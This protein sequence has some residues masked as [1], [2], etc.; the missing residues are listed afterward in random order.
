MPTFEDYLNLSL[1]VY[2]DPPSQ[3]I[4][5]NGPGGTQE[6]V[7]LL[8]P[9]PSSQPG[10]YGAAYLNIATNEIIL[11]NRG[12]NDLA[13]V[14]ADLQM[15]L[16]IPPDQL[17]DAEDFYSQV[18]TEAVARGATLSITGHSLGGS[19]TQLLVA[20]HA[21]DVISGSSVF[22]QTFNA[23]GVKG[24]LNDLNLPDAD[25]A[26]TNWVS[27]TDIVSNLADHIGSKQALA[28]LP[29]PFN[30]PLGPVG[31]LTF[32]YDTHKISQVL[33][34]FN[35]E[36]A[37]PLLQETEEYLVQTYVT[38]PG[39]DATID[40]AAYI[41]GN[42]RENIGNELTGSAA[43][44][45]IFGGLPD[46]RIHGGEGRDVIYA[47]AGNDTIWGDAGA[48]I[49]VG[50]DGDDTYI[51]DDP[52]D[53]V[54]EAALG[55][56]DTVVSTASHTLSRNVEQLI[57]EGT[58]P[59]NGTGND[60]DNVLIGNNADN[61]LDGAFGA[62]SMAGG[63]GD[64][65]YVV[66]NSGDLVSE[67]VA[68]GTDIVNSSVSYALTANVENLIL[69]GAE[70]IDGT[71]NELNNILTGNEAA[72]TLTGSGGNDTLRGEAGFDR[73][74]YRTGD[75]T[76]IIEDVDGQGAILY[77]GHLLLGGLRP[78]GSTGAYTSPDGQFTYVQ[79]GDDIVVNGQLTIR[80]G[81]AGQMGMQ[82][83]ELPAAPTPL[84][85]TRSSFVR[86]TAPGSG[87]YEPIFTEEGNTYGPG[88]VV[89]PEYS[90]TDNHLIHALGGDD[91]VITGNGSDQLYG[92]AGH[93]TLS[94]GGGTDSIDGGEGDDL[95]QGG[96]GEDYVLGGLGNDNLNGDEP[97]AE[98][99]GTNNDWLDGGEGHDE[100][101]G[102]AGSDVLFGG[103]GDDLLIGDTTQFQGG[104][105]EAGD[106]D[107]LFGGD[108]QDTLY[109]LY[110]NDL[111]DGGS[112]DDLMAGQD[113]TDVLSGGD[114]NDVL[115]GDLRVQSNGVI[116][117]AEY[118]GAG[119]SDLLDGGL[120]HD[121]LQGGEGNDVLVG[122]AG[123]DTLFGEYNPNALPGLDPLTPT[124]AALSGADYLTGGAGN[125]QLHGNGGDDL[126]YGDEGNDLL[127]GG[128]G[129]D[130]LDGGTG[131]NTLRGGAGDDVLHGH[132][133]NDYLEAGEGSDILR[134]GDGDDILVG[135]NEY[136][137]TGDSF[138]DGG[139]GNDYY[140]IDRPG[141]IVFEMAGH[142]TDTVESFISYALP[143]EVEN[144]TLFRSGDLHGIGN[145]HDNIMQGGTWLEGGEGNDTLIGGTLGQSVRLDGGAGDDTLQGGIPSLT[146]GINNNVYV[147]GH[148]YGQDAVIEYNSGADFD[149]NQIDVVEMM[150]DVSP[151]DVAW[152]RDNNDLVFTLQ[153]TT[154]HLRLTSYFDLTFNTGNY[155][156]GNAYIPPQGTV[157]LDNRNPYY[158]AASR[159]EEIRFADGTTWEADMFGAPTL[160]AYPSDTYHFDRGDGQQTIIDFDVTGNRNGDAADAVQ[161]GSGIA[162]DEVSVSRRGND[163]VLSLDGAEDVLTV[164]S[165][166]SI[167]FAREQHSFSGNYVTAYQMEQV[168]FDDGTIWNAAQ[169]A[170]RVTA[171]AG[172]NEADFLVANSNNNAIDGL[173]GDD[174]IYGQEGD[175]RIDGGA[176]DDRLF[177]NEGNDTYRFGRGGGQDTVIDWNVTGTDLDT[178]EMAPDVTTGDLRVIADQNGG[179]ALSIRG[180]TDQLTLSDFLYDSYSQNK[181]VL[182]ADGTVWDAQE[183]LA[184][185][186]GPTITGTEYPDYLVGTEFN[187]TI[188]GLE[189]EDFLDGREGADLLYGGLDSDEILGGDGNDMLYGEAGDDTLHGGSGG[190]GGGAGFAAMSVEGF[191]EADCGGGGSSGA[192][193]DDLLIGGEG[194][195]TYLFNFGD[196]VDTIVDTAV[197]GE[198]NRLLFG[199]GIYQSD[200]SFEH[201][202]LS[203]VLTI[204]VGF[205]GD[206][207]RLTNFDPSQANGSLAVET[208]AFADGTEVALS[209]FFAPQP[210]LIGTAGGDYLIGTS[211][212]DII[213]AL[214]GNDYLHGQ[215][216]D[217]ILLGGDGDD[218]LVGGAGADTFDG[219][220]GNDRLYVDEFDTQVSGGAGWDE[221]RIDGTVGVTLTTSDIEYFVGGAGGDHLTYSGTDAISMIGREGNDVLNGGS[222]NDS[223]QGGTGADILDGGAGN[224]SLEGEAGDDTLLGGAGDD[225]LQGGAGAD[226]FDG[227]EGNDRLYVDEFDTQVSGGAG[228]DEVRVLSATGATL[229]LSDVEYVVGGEG[230]DTVTSTH[231]E[232]MMM[233]GLAGN[234][235]LTGGS[236][237][238]SLQGGTGADT[239]DGSAG[240]DSLEGEAGDDTLFGGAGSDSLQGGAGADTLEG[241]AGNDQLYGGT[242]NDRY[243]FTSGNGQDTLVDSDSTEVSMDEVAL[244]DG[245]VPLNVV[246][247]RQANDL[248][249]ALAG[250]ND[251]LTVRDW[252][253]G[254]ASQVEQF[255]AST[256]SRLINSNV[257]QLIQAMNTYSQTAGLSWEDAIQ[258]RPDEVQAVIGAYW[259]QPT[260]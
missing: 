2:G 137:E 144:L 45:L 226:T 42:N 113:G 65:V 34:G 43:N 206:A 191:C 48:D 13:D 94:A 207:L 222:G 257:D 104:P 50:E 129:N 242:G 258:Q 182:F 151:T 214:A 4:A 56:T 244:G 32:P 60:L 40:G 92:D 239:L 180:T 169:L 181:R 211:G 156:L 190:G 220:T 128:A 28:G 21:G 121:Y 84:G 136:F 170:S 199:D 143:G 145:V 6:W 146:S 248:R 90:D 134:G 95:L 122:G 18:Q 178:I 112:G 159:V 217:D 232:A 147:F 17:A 107:L 163:L 44:D 46:D 71:G 161:L 162:Q 221:V 238:D 229:T 209:S 67:A 11:V 231:S 118:R 20:G 106:R 8:E 164:H 252:Y 149:R 1:A 196:G 87:L 223:L 10:Y 130:F 243:L 237:N 216:S 132:D 224:D 116:D 39:F 85:P 102:A 227:G 126:L 114:G 33:G 173:A 212:V 51:V 203:R 110:G 127:D 124:L 175:D 105:P 246:F 29:I 148:G 97:S 240:N 194:H 183:L 119:G 213:D 177:G 150:P 38:D 70:T 192:T 186:E 208:L 83:V 225:S 78:S 205:S 30:Y 74:V 91:V 255:T 171:V 115:S 86:E 247:S 57:L 230:H 140:I 24:L 142:G 245:L 254:A 69:A 236:G 19:L 15:A 54:I 77:D 210:T 251:T 219:G 228:W 37:H 153:D 135:G 89:T 59:I 165:H 256:G 47:G 234:D 168:R 64:D 108:G 155:L 198:G 22:G 31:V 250:T 139:R 179:V 235:R 98:N 66:D 52:D 103:T 188:L 123:D 259:Q 62:D 99:L 109:G 189:G 36:N 157:N 138:L 131:D 75:G 100:L 152:Y 25:Y 172:T 201:D 16:D 26:V 35:T 53:Q 154:D 93:D 141:D 253:S 218:A 184:R 176:G 215:E 23:F 101:H 241:G 200:L 58:G 96:A 204:H 160:G 133:G 79:S 125:D 72:N 80:S 166:F 82:F 117:A 88:A 68:E 55:G 63:I 7:F 167:V 49:M 249:V 120:G 158:F 202:S 260:P 61:V 14:V 174:T 9:H 73:Y 195:D 193:G 187:D 76:D 185:V 5:V 233:L 81:A 111:L 197:A 41:G 12:T 3:T 27:P